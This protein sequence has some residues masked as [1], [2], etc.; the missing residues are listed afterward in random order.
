MSVKKFLRSARAIEESTQKSHHDEAPKHAAGGHDESNW[1]VSYADLMTLLCGFF[2]ILFSMSKMDEPKFEKVKEAV[3]QQFG[4]KYE[5]PTMEMAKFVTQVLDEAGLKKDV[6]VKHDGTGVSV[7]FQST[8][9][10]DTLNAE[11]KAEGQNVLDRLVS[12]LLDRQK[13]NG[14]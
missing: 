14:K 9:F 7:A 3:A 8:V 5:S 6:V 4:G 11:V 1:L 10:F 2:I 12:A 13:A